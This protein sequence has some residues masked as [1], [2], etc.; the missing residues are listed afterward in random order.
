MRHLIRHPGLKSKTPIDKRIPCSDRSTSTA[1]LATD[2]CPLVPIEWPWRQS[3]SPL[4]FRCCSIWV[5]AVLSS[6]TRSCQCQLACVQR[7]FETRSR[8]RASVLKWIKMTETMLWENQTQIDKLYK[9]TWLIGKLRY[10][11]MLI[12][13]DIIHCSDLKGFIW[14]YL[15]VFLSILDYFGRSANKEQK[16]T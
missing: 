9:L 15:D 12:P 4:V 2:P 3:S 10:W 1:G 14:F 11:M 8:F 7:V 13:I 5:H 6:T 16:S